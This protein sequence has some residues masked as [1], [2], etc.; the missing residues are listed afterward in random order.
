MQDVRNLSDHVDLSMFTSELRLADAHNEVLAKLCAETS[1]ETLKH[2]STTNV[3]RDLEY[4]HRTLEGEDAPINY[5]G[6]SYGT[7]IGSYFVNMYVIGI[8]RSTCPNSTRFP[9]RVGRI[10]IDGVAVS[11]PV[12]SATKSSTNFSPRIRIF[13]QIASRIHGEKVVH[14]LNP[15]SQLKLKEYSETSRFLQRYRQDSS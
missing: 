5:W 1:G 2:V 11:R 7:I 12:H 15:K 8:V 3:A 9:D 13:G 4:I 14:E 6:F 10:A